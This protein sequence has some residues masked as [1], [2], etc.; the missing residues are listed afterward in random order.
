M[1]LQL[2]ITAA[3][4]FCAASLPTATAQNGP[5]GLG[6]SP[7]QR[8]RPVRSTTPQPM[9]GPVGVSAVFPF[10]YRTIDGVGNNVANPEWGASD[11]PML[12]MVAA[13]YADGAS[14][15]SGASRP[16]VREI[17]NAVIAQVGSIPN[18][19]GASDFV[20]QWGQFLD[21]DLDETPG[22]AQLETFDIDVPMGD[23]WF[24][25]FSTGTATI[26]LNR[27]GYD[28]VQGV[29][30]QVNAITAYL[31]ASNVYGSDATRAQALRTMD[32]TGR[33]RT[34]PGDLLPYNTVGLPNAPDSSSTLFLAGDVRA[35][36][37]IGLTT[38]H[39]LF[40]REHNYWAT[41][42]LNRG[43]MAG[44]Q[45]YEWAKAIVTAEMQAI[46]Y[47]EFLPALL[48]PGALPPYQ[49]YRPQVDAS[50]GNLFATAAYRFGHTM[51]SPQLRRLEA[52]GSTHL[53][54]DLPLANAFFDP[55]QLTSIGLEPYLRGLADQTAQEIDGRIVD[56][57]R[58][59]LFGPPGSGGF[60]LASLNI[61]RGRDH[62]LPNYNAV[63]VAFGR[64]VATSWSEIT[65]DPAAQ[66]RMSSIH[67]SVDDL[68]PWVGLLCE[69][70][71]PGALVGPTLKAILTDQ[72]VR[73]RDGD[74]FWYQ[75]YLPAPLA[76]RLERQ[77]LAMIIRRNTAIGA[78]LPDDVFH[79]GP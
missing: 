55:T 59:F 6:R 62:G 11:T 1:K 74:R 71:A 68:D 21:H 50:I 73:I 36:E 65:A 56:G 16:N 48:G 39:T 9:L 23:A 38:M 63:R 69:D 67:A 52:D 29:R 60:D 18:G 31:D 10:E 13:D 26:P 34:S 30:E 76:S 77:T 32:G 49:G 35:N 5:Q 51:L 19:D 8:P 53:A 14:A 15:P 70:H 44:D 17:S 28:M 20:W 46:T 45:I 58:N 72:F 66:A 2:G 47:R 41:L 54:G 40:V 43:P 75:S 78:E 25:P 12:R 64:P 4:L 33:L 22:G 27:S 24:D 37:Q 3:T 79:V 7:L 61:Q 57:V 42:L